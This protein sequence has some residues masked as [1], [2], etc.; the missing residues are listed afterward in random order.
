VRKELAHSLRFGRV[1]W[2]GL[3]TLDGPETQRKFYGIPKHAQRPHVYAVAENAYQ[4]L[5]SNS[6]ENQ[7]IV[8]TGE[9]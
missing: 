4:A 2:V 1:T 9:S 8:I 7:T 6:K 5:L 3:T